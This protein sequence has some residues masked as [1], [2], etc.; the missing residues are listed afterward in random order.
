[1]LTLDTSRLGSVL[2]NKSP[3]D[4]R[5]FA[6]VEP[7]SSTGSE[8]LPVTNTIRP[9]PR[10]QP[11]PSGGSGPGGFQL[12]G[13]AWLILA[14]ILAVVFTICVTVVCVYLLISSGQGADLA[15]VLQA[16]S[17]RF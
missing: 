8:F 3:G 11:P 2:K 14:A 4:N 12:W 17:R 10:P 1:M 9:N 16:I 15:L 13:P 5:G 6:T 7:A